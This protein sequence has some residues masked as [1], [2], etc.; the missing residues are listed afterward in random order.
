MTTTRLRDLF[1][2]MS[3]KAAKPKT[4]MSGGSRE[5]STAQADQPAQDTDDGAGKEDKSQRLLSC[6]H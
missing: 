5:L 3:C 4:P 6:R 2:M 1:M